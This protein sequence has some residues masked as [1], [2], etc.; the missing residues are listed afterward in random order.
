V[1]IDALARA[2]DTLARRGAAAAL[3]ELADATTG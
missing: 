3:H 2:L 1:W